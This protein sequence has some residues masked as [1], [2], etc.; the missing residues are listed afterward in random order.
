M[1][2]KLVTAM[3]CALGKN[4]RSATDFPRRKTQIFTLIEL[5]IVIAIIAILAA[6][7]LPALQKVKS[8]GYAIKC[9]SNLRQLGTG[10]NIYSSDYNDFLPM[11]RCPADYKIDGRVVY[12]WQDLLVAAKSIPYRDVALDAHPPLSVFACPAES[13]ETLEG[14]SN[15]NSWKGTHYGMNYFAG[16]KT[17]TWGD[18]ASRIYRKVSRIYQPSKVFYIMDKGPGVDSGSGAVRI[19]ANY[20]RASYKTVALRHEKSFNVTMI[21]GHVENFNANDAAA[22]RIYNTWISL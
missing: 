4:I 20:V 1:K 3:R 13:R 19:A 12:Y 22:R 17:N 6:M 16:Y 11:V 2:E 18:T 14:N 8:K 21:D 7:L 5:L 15:W 9:V 10:A